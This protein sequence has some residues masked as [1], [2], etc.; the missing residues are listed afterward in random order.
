MQEAFLRYIRVLCHDILN[1]LQ[2]ISGLSQLQKTE[3]IRAYVHE[4]SDQI[5]EIGRLARIGHPGLAAGVFGFLQWL[6][7]FGIPYRLQVAEAGTVQ[8]PRDDG[9]AAVL[10]RGLDVLGRQLALL[11]GVDRPVRIAVEVDDGAY[12]VRITLPGDEEKTVGATRN[13]T[14][15]FDAAPAGSVQVANEDGATVLL[16]TLPVTADAVRRDVEE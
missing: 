16:V 4:V 13:C 6:S 9:L 7:R 14:S 3:R 11:E 8:A 1:H 10:A 2:V 15:C 12:R 5:K